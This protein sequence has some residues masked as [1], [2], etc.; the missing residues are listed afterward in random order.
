MDEMLAMTLEQRRR[1]PGLQPERADI[2]CAGAAIM[3]AFFELSGAQVVYA[4]DSDNLMGYL[5]TNAHML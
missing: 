1:I 3:M 2:I 4:S 5:R